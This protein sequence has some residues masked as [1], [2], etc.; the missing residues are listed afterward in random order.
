MLYWTAP[1]RPGS[2]GLRNHAGAGAI[3][4]VKQESGETMKGWFCIGL[5]GGLAVAAVSGLRAEDSISWFEDRVS[6]GG[7]IRGRGELYGNF[8][9]PDGRSDKDDE[10]F[11]L[12]TKMHLDVHPDESWRVFIEG[13]DSREFGS[14]WNRRSAVPNA[15]EDDL[16]LFQ[17][18]LD[19]RHI[20][21]SPLSLR[22][23]RQVLSY[24]KQ[25][26][27][28]GFLWSNV[29]RSFDALLLNLDWPPEV[30]GS[31]DLFIGKPVIHD[32]GNFNDIFHNDDLFYGLYTTWK[33][34]PGLDFL[35]GYY[36]ARD[37]DARRDH[38]HTLGVRAGRAYDNRWDWEIELAGQAGE[39]TDLDHTAF[40]AHAEAGYTLEPAW[41]PRVSLGYSFATGD[42]DP[43]DG[44]HGTFDNLF[45]TNHIHYGYMDLFSWRNLHDVELE[46][47][48]YPVERLKVLSE[49]YGFFLPEPDSDAWYNAAGGVLRRAAA[50]RDARAYVGAELDFMATWRI[51]DQ[52]TLEAGYSHFFAG[53]YVRDTG[54]S[55]DADWGYLQGT[56]TF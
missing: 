28:G 35:E 13:Q 21:D 36:L 2:G 46:F 31:I 37:N 6:I 53:D 5:W 3:F 34:V 45:P 29:A 10:F 8:Y 12:R 1:A 40:A 38:V 25:R 33:S 44:E 42:E 51:H 17:A 32:W 24:G 48:A 54:A 15:M 30:K 19:L 56:F 50:G 9:T 55:G 23:G 49:V 26:L 11:L 18:Y 43:R 16:D 47:S 39:F 14:D 22:A 41:K 4:Q 52:F 27:V 7:E 20:A